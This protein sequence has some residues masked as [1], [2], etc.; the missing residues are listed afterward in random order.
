M[1]CGVAPGARTL[2]L[3]GVVPAFDRE[4]AVIAVDWAAAATMPKKKGPKKKGANGA[5]KEAK[6]SAVKTSPGSGALRVPTAEERLWAARFAISETARKEHRDNAALLVK[7]NGLLLQRAEDTE[8]D[9]MEVVGFLRRQL[10]QKDEEAT[11][12]KEAAKEAA[13]AALVER[14]RLADD[15]AQRLAAMQ[16]R[17]DGGQ[18]EAAALTEELAKLADFR[19]LR[20]RMEEDVCRLRD[21]SSERDQDHEQK[22]QRMETRFMEEKVRK[23]ASP[24]EAVCRCQVT[25]SVGF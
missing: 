25:T 4:L 19:R 22:L 16:A 13:R 3:P 21:L 17:V 7:E 8:R 11:S 15:C 12:A 18:R 24:A 23:S 6:S 14:D 20:E 5:K 1:L 9:S 10:A 2:L